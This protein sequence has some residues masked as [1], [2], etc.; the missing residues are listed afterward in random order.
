MKSPMVTNATYIKT[1][2]K[3]GYTDLKVLKSAAGH[4]IGTLYEERNSSGEVVFVEPGSRD[5]DY[6]ANEES[7]LAFLKALEADTEEN[8]ANLL[9]KHP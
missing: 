2:E 8:A 3:S 5:S 9:R 6:F 4:Y 1:E 7:A